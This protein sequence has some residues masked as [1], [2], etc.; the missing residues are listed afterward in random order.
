MKTKARHIE[1]LN[2]PTAIMEMQL[3]TVSSEKVM[4]FLFYLEFKTGSHI[5]THTSDSQ[6]VPFIS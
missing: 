6:A 4:K 5:T 2:Q 1:Q 3:G